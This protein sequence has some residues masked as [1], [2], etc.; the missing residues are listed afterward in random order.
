MGRLIDGASTLLTNILGFGYG[1]ALFLGD[2][3]RSSVLFQGVFAG[4]FIYFVF[5]LSGVLI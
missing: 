2:T 4:F 3:A 1:T 5:Y